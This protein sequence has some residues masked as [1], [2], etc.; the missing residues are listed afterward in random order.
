MCGDNSIPA[1]AADRRSGSAAATLA[2]LGAIAL[3]AFLALLNR[4]AAAI[5][6][7]EL[8]TLAFAV[9]ALAGGAV[10]VLRGRLADLRQPPLVWLHGVGGL[11]GYQAMYFLALSL[12]PAAEAS[13]IQYLWP[14]LLVLLS[15]ILLGARLRVGH[16]AGVSLGFGGT[17]LLLVQGASFSPAAASGY[18]AA[19]GAACIWALYS[20]V[21]PAFAAVPSG[22]VAGFCAGSAVLAAVMHFAVERTIMPPV[23]AS[24][25]AIAIGLGP[26]GGAYFLWDVGMKKG[27]PRLLGTLAYAT[28]VAST[29]VLVIAGLAPATTALAV[30]ALLVAIGGLITAQT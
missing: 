14:L 13:L 23:G 11:F 7:L 9:T 17:I 6:P 19:F 29:V 2:G 12:A 28:P 22:A 5:P 16:L 25:A 24:I 26:L 21:A 18:L 1:R 27:D 4:E 10:L 3:W 30:A 8:T 20:V 15:A